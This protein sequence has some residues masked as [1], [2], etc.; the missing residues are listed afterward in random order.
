MHTV[1]HVILHVYVCLYVAKMSLWER[2]T[3]QHC[4]YKHLLWIL[5][6]QMIL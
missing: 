4:L 3:I 2:Q 6:L 1:Y 5:Q